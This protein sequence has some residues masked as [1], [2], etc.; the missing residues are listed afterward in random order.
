MLNTSHPKKCAKLGLILF[1]LVIIAVLFSYFFIFKH[2][3][4]TIA[5]N[6]KI[7][8][9]YLQKSAPI[10]DFDLMN[11][12]GQFFT[13]KSLKGQWTMMVF[14]FINCEYV[15]PTTLAELNQMYNQLQKTLPIN[16]LPQIVLVTVDPER[17]TVAK[18]KKYVNSFN[19]HFMGVTGELD[20]IQKLEKQLHITAVKMQEEGQPKDQYKVK[21]SAEI[22]IF[23]PQGEL[24]A[25]LSY[26]HKADQMVKDYQLILEN[27]S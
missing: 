14:G 15:C 25:Y 4:I 13:K 1:M 10:N 6:I 20:E 21:H 8:G 5:Q 11:S 16:Q 7:D 18:M 9:E 22:L 23:N 26:P 27:V 3:K 17:D 24:Q 19:H 12:Q 2:E